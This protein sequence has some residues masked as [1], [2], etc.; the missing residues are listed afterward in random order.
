MVYEPSVD[1]AGEA[2][3]PQF[4]LERLR[5]RPEGTASSPAA[6][7]STRCGSSQYWKFNH[8]RGSTPAA[9]ARWVSRHPAAIGAKGRPPGPHGVGGRRRRCF[10]MTAQELV[11]A[12]T[13]RIRSGARSQTAYLGMVRRW[14]RCSTRRYSSVP[15]A[16][17]ADYVKWSK[18]MG[19]VAM[20]VESRGIGPAIGKDNEIDDQARRASEFR[21]DS[22]EKA[23][24]MVVPAARATT[25]RGGPG[26][27]AGV[28]PTERSGHDQRIRDQRRAPATTCCRCWSRTVMAG[29]E[30]V[31]PAGPQAS[32]LLAVACKPTRTASKA[33]SPSP[34]STWRAH[35]LEQIVKQLPQTSSST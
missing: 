16:R 11:T 23:F 5:P 6:S 28:R 21:T 22:A 8:R 33:A 25:D 12:A 26:V 15:V 27:A 31:R 7:A 34:W 9:W 4:V 35:P 3:K 10:Q 17:P 30:P 13:E 18:A 14:R 32:T 19:C 24:P 2:L 1:G 29:L 20:R